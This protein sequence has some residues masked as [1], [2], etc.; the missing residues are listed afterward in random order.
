M[1]NCSCLV[2]EGQSPDLHKSELQ[3]AISQFTAS[4][5]GQEAQIA[6]IPV[7]VGD[8]FTE[9]KKSTSSVVSITANEPLTPARRETL[10]REFVALWTDKTGSTIDE[11]VI[12][13]VDP[14][15]TN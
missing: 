7:A 13:I 2:Q 4:S 15:E 12:A 11:I 6:W 8:G 14:A 9:G 1:I 10:L 3:A 5:F